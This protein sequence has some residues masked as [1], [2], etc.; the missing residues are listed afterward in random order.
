MVVTDAPSIRLT[1]VMQER[2]ARPSTC[3]VQAPHIPMPH[4]NLVPVRF[5]VSRITHSS[6]VS[7]GTSADIGLPLSVKVVVMRWAL[8]RRGGGGRAGWASARSCRLAAAHLGDDAGHV[9]PWRQ[10][11]ARLAQVDGD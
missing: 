2:V 9:G 3:T 10:R 8:R 4:P 1:G 6:G 11:G 5:A 7:S